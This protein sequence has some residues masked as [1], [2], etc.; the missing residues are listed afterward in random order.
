M[1]AAAHVFG[2]E[3]IGGLWGG[4]G[5]ALPDTGERSPGDYKLGFSPRS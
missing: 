2:P 1:I 4:V 5:P 3:L